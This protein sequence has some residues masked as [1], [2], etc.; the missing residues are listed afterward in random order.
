[1][2]ITRLPCF[3]HVNW[4]PDRHAR[5]GFALAMLVGFFVLGLLVAWRADRWGTAAFVL[6]GFGVA[7]AVGAML[8]AVGRLVY[9]GVTLPTSL[10][11]YVI[12]HLLLA[13][14]YFLVFTP[15]GWTLRRI[16]HDPLRLRPR[17]RRP[18][19]IARVGERDSG[20]YYRQF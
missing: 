15:L 2:D 11:G 7:L 5:R 8:P 6:W 19:W 9:L 18:V 10:I 3:H 20:D 13:L 12:S 1:M 17:G 14:I 4:Q 16:G